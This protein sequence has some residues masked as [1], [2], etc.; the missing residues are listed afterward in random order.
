[1]H[2]ESIVHVFHECFLIKNL[3]FKIE[4]VLSKMTNIRIKLTVKDI[5]LGYKIESN[6][7]SNILVNNVLLHVKWFIWK[8][9]IMLSIPSYEH[10][11]R[12]ISSHVIVEQSLESFYIEM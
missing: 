5:I 9:R 10:L 1:M 7:M 6:P 11:K 4:A 2:K 12:F 3:W 8:C